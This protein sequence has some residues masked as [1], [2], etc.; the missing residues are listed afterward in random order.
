MDNC[1][2][3]ASDCWTYSDLKYSWRTPSS[4]RV[5]TIATKGFVFSY[6][7]ISAMGGVVTALPSLTRLQHHF[8][9]VIFTAEKALYAAEN[10]VC[11]SIEFK[12]NSEVIKDIESVFKSLDEEGRIPKVCMYKWLYSCYSNSSFS[13]CGSRVVVAAAVVVVVVVPVLQVK[14][15]L[16]L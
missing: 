16:K 13:C 12:D 1:K 3:D 9:Y 10:I 11:E 4:K 7:Y 2:I 5:S 8:N 15:A 14:A 6:L